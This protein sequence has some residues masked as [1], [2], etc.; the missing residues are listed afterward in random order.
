MGNCQPVPM[1]FKVRRVTKISPFRVRKATILPRTHYAGYR[2]SLSAVEASRTS[3][4]AFSM[5]HLNQDRDS[6]GEGSSGIVDSSC[7]VSVSVVRLR[8]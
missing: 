2:R 5:S 1:N 3:H 4:S 8:R 7:A 6:F